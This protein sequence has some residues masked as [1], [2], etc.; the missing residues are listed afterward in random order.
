MPLRRWRPLLRHRS[1]TRP[2]KGRGG[3]TGPTSADSAPRATKTA[4][5]LALLRRPGGATL[6]EIRNATGWQ[7][8]SVRGFLSGKVAK[9]MGLKV[10]SARRADG[11][12]VYS[13]VS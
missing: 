9:R 13:I 7:A 3:R 6:E 5:V 11:S 1:L 12:R 10:T 8:H 4:L 2:P